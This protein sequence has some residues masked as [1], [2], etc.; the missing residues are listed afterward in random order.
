MTQQKFDSLLHHHIL[1]TFIQEGHAPTNEQLARKVATSVE[2]VESGLLRLQASHAVVLHPGRCELWVVHPFSLSPT[3]TWVQ[4]SKG[5]WWAPCMGCALG[6]AALVKGKL[7]VHSRIGGEAE[8]VKVD[9]VDGVPMQT[10]LFVHWP[11]PPRMNWDN[12]HHF[13]ARLLPF[14]SPE[15]VAEWGRRH[16]LPVGKILPITQL[17]EFSRRWYSNHADAEWEKWTLTQATEIF[18]STGLTGDFWKLDTT[19]ERF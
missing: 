9:V 1:T 13:C 3:H 5:G 19:G 18:S 8:P 4:A 7:T 2:N 16:Q 12:I 17:A 11:E 15:D 10:E 6:I 14:R